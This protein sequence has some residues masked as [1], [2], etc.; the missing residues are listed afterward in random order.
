M[1]SLPPESNRRPDLSVGS[2]GIPS[3]QNQPV[4]LV[5]SQRQSPDAP[6]LSHDKALTERKIKP[7]SNGLALMV[8]R[9]L[10]V[11]S[12]WARDKAALTLLLRAEQA[13]RS[14]NSLKAIHWINQLQFHQGFLETTEEAIYQRF[15][16][17]Y[18]N[19][20]G[21][22]ENTG[23]KLPSPS[24]VKK[25]QERRIPDYWLVLGS[26]DSGKNGL[27]QA[28]G[29]SYPRGNRL[30]E[31][32]GKELDETQFKDSGHLYIP[33]KSL[34][35]KTMAVQTGTQNGLSEE[36][37][38]TIQEAGQVT[39][40]FN[41]LQPDLEIQLLEVVNLLKYFQ[42]HSMDLEKFHISLTCAHQLGR[43]FSD[44]AAWWCSQIKNRLVSEAG[45]AQEQAEELISNRLSFAGSPLLKE[46]RRRATKNVGKDW[47]LKLFPEQR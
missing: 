29:N 20:G 24:V 42:A 35:Y 18:E 9:V 21:N 38:N 8:C 3:S 19:L 12:N 27:V 44:E 40:T 11:V 16:L 46:S 14:G 45:L 41:M 25:W 43:N 6:F 15:K 1:D 32:V 4:R 37:S 17:L 31:S 10:S 30:F 39:Y 26:E 22:P 7:L 33:G 2:P 28:M 13:H 23:V 34:K 5:D 36:L 47:L